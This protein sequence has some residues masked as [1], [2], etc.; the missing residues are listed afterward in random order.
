M[1]KAKP[2]VEH[3]PQEPLVW[4]ISGTGFIAIVA[5]L[6]VVLMQAF[7]SSAPAYLTVVERARSNRAEVTVLTVDVRNDGDETA[8]GVGVR[9]S[10]IHGAVSEVQLDYVPGRSQ[11]TAT[12]LFPA[13]SGAVTLA[14][15]GW[16]DP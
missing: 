16:S 8:A 4:I 7:T 15:S 11:R 12:L 1:V 2:K 5:A 6:M 14:V 9:G 13:N 3:L 10:T